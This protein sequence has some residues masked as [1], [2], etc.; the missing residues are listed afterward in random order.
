MYQSLTTSSTGHDLLTFG[1]EALSVHRAAERRASESRHNQITH[2][3]REMGHTSPTR[4]WLGTMMIALG[5]LIAGQPVRTPQ[6]DATPSA[7]AGTK[8]APM[9]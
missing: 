4:R 8:L 1:N 3:L 6:R 7:M 5:T 2:I 9:R